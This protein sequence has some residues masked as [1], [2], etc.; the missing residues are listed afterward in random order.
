MR[1]TKCVSDNLSDLTVYISLNIGM[2]HYAALS[3]AASV[4]QY[5]L[6]N[7]GNLYFKGKHSPV[8]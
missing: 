4:N 7:C 5:A 2:S 6:V 1:A 8:N 3:K